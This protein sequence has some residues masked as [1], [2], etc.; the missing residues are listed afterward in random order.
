MRARSRPRV[1]LVHAQTLVRAGL[2]AAMRDG[3]SQSAIE[4]VAQ[5]SNAADAHDALHRLLD[6]PG[7]VVVTID[8]R[9][10]DGDGVAAARTLKAQRPDL[11]VVVLG[12]PGADD[13]RLVFATLDAGLSAYVSADAPVSELIAAVRHAAVAP[14]AFS[15]ANLRSAMS[16]RRASTGPLLSGR[17]WEVLCLMRDGAT[18][19]HIAEALRVSESTVKT[20]VSRLYAKLKVA[21]RSQ[22]LVVA[23]REGLIEHADEWGHRGGERVA[24]RMPAAG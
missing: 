8:A 10:T 19:P 15:G 20:Y 7:P 9:L 11:G 22:A 13:D 16:R 23:L 24:E 21:N 6:D 2:A 17:E 14:D 12:Q 18:L 3:D 4:V 1:V 5:A